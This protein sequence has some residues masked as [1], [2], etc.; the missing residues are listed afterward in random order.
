MLRTDVTAASTPGGAARTTA[1]GLTG[2]M[3]MW[4]VIIVN[5]HWFNSVV[6]VLAISAINH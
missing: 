4:L 1:A 3:A 5:S 6:S 2:V